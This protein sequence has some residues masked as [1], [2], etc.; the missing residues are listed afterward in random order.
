MNFKSFPAANPYLCSMAGLFVPGAAIL[1]G[2]GSHHIYT[3]DVGPDP[4]NHFQLLLT[5]HLF[6]DAPG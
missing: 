5:L 4:V 6:H 1:M 3:A 2:I